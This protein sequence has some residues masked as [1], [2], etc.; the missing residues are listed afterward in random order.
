MSELTSTKLYTHDCNRCAYLGSN[1]L[2][3]L[4]VCYSGAS[5]LTSYVARHSNEP[6]DNY[7]LPDFVVEQVRSFSPAYKAKLELD[8]LMTVCLEK[9][10]RSTY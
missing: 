2:H 3:D 10:R 1:K 9:Q 7:S 4:Y 6:S 5:G 8:E